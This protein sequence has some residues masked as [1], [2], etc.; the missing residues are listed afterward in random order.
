MRDIQRVLDATD[1]RVVEQVATWSI[2]GAQA[3]E[4]DVERLAAEY[5]ELRRAVVAVLDEADRH[6]RECAVRVE[7]VCTCGAAA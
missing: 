4:R 7:P 2:H 3:S 6:H 5:L 1:P